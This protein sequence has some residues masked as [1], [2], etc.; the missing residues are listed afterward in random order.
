MPLRPAA[1]LPAHPQPLCSA[2]K[3]T[4]EQRSAIAAYFAVYKGQEKGI[5][6]LATA[7]DDHPAVQRAYALLK[8]AFEEVGSACCCYCCC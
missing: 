1:H 3:L 5:A 2:R 6:K 7:L 8:D 4:D